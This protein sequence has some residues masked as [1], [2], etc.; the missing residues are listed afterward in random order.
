MDDAPD[1]DT[2]TLVDMLRAEKLVRE[3]ILD[4]AMR[5]EPFQVDGFM[6]L[7][8]LRVAAENRIK[9]LMRVIETCDE[10]IKLSELCSTNP[11]TK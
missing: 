3:F 10:L 9:G 6:N 8:A 11:T 1:L 5:G 4:E 2:T 7:T